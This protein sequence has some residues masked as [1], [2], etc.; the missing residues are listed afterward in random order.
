MPLTVED[1][2]IVAGADSFVTVAEADTYW[3]D[4]GSPAD[5]VDSSP[6]NKEARL[7]DATRYL[8][9]EQR[10]PYLGSR[11][12]W[13][14]PLCWP[15]TGATSGFLPVPDNAIPPQVKQAQLWLSVRGYQMNII[16]EGAAVAPVSGNTKSE[17]VGNLSAS[18]F[19][20]E[21]MAKGMALAQGQ[22]PQDVVGILYPLL[23]RTLLPDIA[24]T[25]AMPTV[26]AGW[27]DPT[28]K[29]RPVWPRDFPAW[30]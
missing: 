24:G 17:S 25:K 26:T 23:D 8:Q 16:G 13:D 27:I 12:A 10:L 2:T 28:T 19:S 6:E 22:A 20:A 9:D 14:Q 1:G 21:E 4:N 7:R 11:I 18:Y 15:R 3:A 29:Q 30:P 5:W